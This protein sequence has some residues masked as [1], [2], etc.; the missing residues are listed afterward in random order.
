MTSDSVCG[1]EFRAIMRR[2]KRKTWEF[3]MQ[4]RL[5]V[6]LDAASRYLKVLLL[7]LLLELRT[8]FEDSVQQQL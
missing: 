7:Q 6:S 4:E 2:Q 1:I 3:A 8:R 5:A